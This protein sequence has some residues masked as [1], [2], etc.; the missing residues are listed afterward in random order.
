MLLKEINVMNFLRTIGVAC[1]VLS[2][3]QIMN[4]AEPPLKKRELNSGE[5]KNIAP[6][7]IEAAKRGDSIEV[8][9]IL[10]EPDIDPNM[11]D[12]DGST[13]LHHATYKG[14]GHIVELLLTNDKTDPNVK[15]KYGR[16]PLFMAALRGHAQIVE[17]LLAN[18]KTDP[19]SSQD[20]VTGLEI[21][22]IR[23]HGNV[24]DLFCR[25]LG[26]DSLKIPERCSFLSFEQ[27]DLNGAITQQ[28]LFSL[29][30][31]V[32]TISSAF[33]LANLINTF[34]FVKNYFNSGQWSLFLNTAC[35]FGV[36]IPEPV[37]DVDSL[38]YKYGLKDLVYI[39]PQDVVK[40]LK[41]LSG[42][43][44]YG[45]LIDHFK[46]IVD[47]SSCQHP[48]RFYLCGHGKADIAIASV[49]VVFTD[50]LLTVFSDLNTEFLYV[51]SCEVAGTN[52]L[53][54]QSAIS[55]LSQH[56]KSID[57]AIV[58]QATSDIGCKSNMALNIFFNQLNDFLKEPCWHHG[59]C[60]HGNSV[61]S[62]PTIAA[63]VASSGTVHKDSLQSIRFP[64][65][66]KFFRSLDLGNMEIIT[67]S[68]L[69]E[70]RV[71]K[72]L[73]LRDHIQNSH[74]TISWRDA[75]EIMENMKFKVPIKIKPGTKYI[76]IFPCDLTDCT[77]TIEQNEVPLFISKIPG[78]GQHFIGAIKY[79]AQE[80]TFEDALSN[81]IKRGFTR[82]VGGYTADCATHKCWFIKSLELTIQDKPVYIKNLVINIVPKGFVAIKPEQAFKGQ[83]CSCVFIDMDGE[84]VIW[85]KNFNEISQ[86]TGVKNM[87]GNCVTWS[88]GRH[89]AGPMNFYATCGSQKTG[90]K[91]EI[92]IETVRNWFKCS[93]PSNK[94]LFEASGGHEFA[95]YSS[96]KQRGT[97]ESIADHAFARFL[98]GL[99]LGQNL[100]IGFFAELIIADRDSVNEF[101]YTLCG[102]H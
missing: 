96:I 65:F 38:H 28:Q 68:R 97:Q 82:L 13:A 43:V 1:L 40:E 55:Q 72:I 56:K 19:H 89:I 78:Q 23:N 42:R 17:L 101:C 46:A 50:K 57:Y 81:F 29:L 4:G 86:N 80:A 77:F 52:L 73:S 25:T 90:V 30:H 51:N 27:G 95:P 26:L 5:A 76:Q 9:R 85:P 63:I 8:R 18:K 11:R 36:I 99:P 83:T 15:D 12:E 100:L 39:H 92:F 54:I 79:R 47:S 24:V 87:H 49:P 84:C 71:A 35:D 16:A 2:I 31:K 61:D 88:E 32:M 21:A 45:Q 93:M 60:C 41:K 94:A 62:T 75:Y 64:G 70:L 102:S 34:P 53:A 44:D 6:K 20:G 37:Y 33:M 74:S 48:T 69:I 58:L 91:K 14:H 59:N 98:I 67:I 3:F 66:G 10:N 7:L 22:A